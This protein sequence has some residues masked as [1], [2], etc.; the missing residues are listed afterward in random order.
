MYL[1]QQFK[2]YHGNVERLIQHE[3]NLSAVFASRHPQVLYFQAGSALG[4]ILYFFD[5]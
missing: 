5:Y 2:H 1:I 4:D 3:A